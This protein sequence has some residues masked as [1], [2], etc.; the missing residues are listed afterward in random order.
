VDPLSAGLLIALAI[1][2]LVAFILLASLELYAESVYMVQ[3]GGKIIVTLAKSDTFKHLN[4]SIYGDG[5]ESVFESAYHHGSEFISSSLQSY[6][7]DISHNE[8]TA[9]ELTKKLLILWDR[10]YQYWLAQ[11]KLDGGEDYGPT[12][13]EGAVVTSFD[14]LLGLLQPN[15]NIVYEYGRENMGTLLGK[16]SF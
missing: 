3:G 8:S 10:M 16:L 11:R 1:I 9:A 14:E 6:L 7:G 15:W 4:S 13:N 12:V 5:L 2:A